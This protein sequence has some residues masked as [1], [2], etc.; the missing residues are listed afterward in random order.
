ML[1]LTILFAVTLL[2]AACANIQPEKPRDAHL[3]SPIPS[4]GAAPLIRVKLSKPSESDRLEVKPGEA[5]LT[6]DG[7][8]TEAEGKLVIE[9]TNEGMFVNGRHF[10]SSLEVSSNADPD[11]FTINNRIYRGR[12]RVLATDSGWEV[13][14]VVD[15]EQY[16]A[17]VIGWEMIAGWPIESLRAQAVASRT[18]AIFEMQHARD[19]GRQ[20]DLDDTT[21]Y[22]VYGGVGPADEPHLWRET[23]NVLAAREQTNGM[24]LTYQ[25]QGFRAFFHSTSGGHTTDP[26]VGFGVDDTITPLQGVDLGEF[27]KESP[28]HSWTVTMSNSEVKARLIEARIEPHDLIRIDRS[29]TAP[30]GHAITLRLYNR[31][32]HFRHAAAIDVRRALGLASTNFE[33]EKLGDEWTFTGR[34]FGHGCG[35]CQWSARGMAA[36]GWKAER[37][38]ETMYPG[39]ELKAIY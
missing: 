19:K 32:G 24:I 28:R 10:E 15:L 8:R 37:I 18:Y 2:V 30:S 13:V 31:S 16:V 36:A 6:V 3:L 34:G 7:A 38:L 23:A 9:R 22:Q 25:G 26:R 11:H 35:M 4:Y 20:W 1:R 17:G 39:S 14:N 12:L 29:E 5:W 27:G 21:N 33:A